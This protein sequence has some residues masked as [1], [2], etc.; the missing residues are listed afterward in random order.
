M[1]CFSFLCV[2]LLFNNCLTTA[3]W[4]LV[5]W[6]IQT[7][8]QLVLWSHWTLQ[9]QQVVGDVISVSSGNRNCLASYDGVYGK[10]RREGGEF[11]R[12]VQL[13]LLFEKIL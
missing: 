12:V 1:R 9:V 13:N 8:S 10:S 4:L 5:C 3:S 6:T 2:V 7:S 11:R